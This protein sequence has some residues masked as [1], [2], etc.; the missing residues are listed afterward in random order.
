M[1][2]RRRLLALLAVVAVAGCAES[3][4]Y[5][6]GGLREIYVLSV[7]NLAP[8]PHPGGALSVHAVLSD[9]LLPFAPSADLPLYVSA[10]SG[11]LERTSLGP[12]FCPVRR[13]GGYQHSCLGIVIT[14]RDGE[15]VRSIEPRLRAWGGRLT[16][17]APRLRFAS[18]LSIRHNS[19]PQRLKEI[20]SWPGVRS[21]YFEGRP[22][23]V[24]NWPLPPLRAFRQTTMAIEDE[25]VAVGDG[26]VQAAPG[27]TIHVTYRQPSGALLAVSAV[28][29]PKPT[30]QCWFFPAP[31]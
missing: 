27:D 15:D 31:C 7:D 11:D 26:V 17:V 24:G 18:A 19:L 12:R 4:T 6:T 28:V 2:T 9:T 29:Q 10:S 25:P 21:A 14:M 5:G 16:L 20:E 3:P 30:D 13:E 23:S 22:G 8:P 1:S